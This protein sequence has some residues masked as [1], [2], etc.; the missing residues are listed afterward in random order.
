MTDVIFALSGRSLPADYAY[1]L[2][3]EV[4]RVLPWL[5]EAGAG[6][7]PLRAP[8]QG[9][10]LLLHKRA[11][12]VLRIPAGLLE[13][14]RQLS[15][16]SLDVGGHALAVGE[17]RERPLQPSPTLHAQLVASSAPEDEFLQ[18]MASEMQGHGIAGKLICGKHHTLP[19]SEGKISG[20][21]LVVHELKPQDALRLQ[22][23]GLGGERHFGCGIFI[24]YKVITNLDGQTG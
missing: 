5:A 8:E 6:I 14:A 21:S 20:F 22:G 7:M 9:D 18:A 10:D 11:R 15:G 16:K 17:A 19:G 1:A 24:P 13:Q 3:R 23:C 4:A 2:W 12:L